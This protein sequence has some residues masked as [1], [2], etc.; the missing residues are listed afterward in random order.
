MI[1]RTTTS[2]NG[3]FPVLIHVTPS[4]KPEPSVDEEIRTLEERVNQLDPDDPRYTDK[5]TALRDALHVWWD[6][7]ERTTPW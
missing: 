3:C 2:R 6:I 1:C 7:R 4:Q 5:L